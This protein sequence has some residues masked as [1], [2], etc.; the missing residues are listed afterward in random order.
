M[1]VRV[2]VDGRPLLTASQLSVQEG[3]TPINPADESGGTAQVQF[4]VPVFPGWK[5]ADELP[6]LVRDD[7]QGITSGK[8]AA[9]AEQ[10]GSLQVTANSRILNLAVTR[11]AQPYAGTLS[12]AIRYYLSL[13]GI[14]TNISIDAQYDSVPVVFPGWKDDVYQRVARRLCPAFG[15]E[16]SLV[17]DVVVFRPPRGRK[18]ILSRVI[19]VS[20]SIDIS[21]R[22]QRSKLNWYKTRW[23]TDELVYP[24]GGWTPE[25][26]VL[27]VNA[28]EVNVVEGI[29][30]N[31]SLSSIRQPA[32][33]VTVPPTFTGDSVYTVSGTDGLPIPP[34]MWKAYGGDLTVAISEDTRSLTVTIRGMELDQY[35]PYVI[36][37]SSGDGT[38]YSTLRL[39]GSG[40]V[41]DAR[42]MDLG[43]GWSADQAP[44]EY[45]DEVD[46]EFLNTYDR[47]GTGAAWQSAEA[48]G[49][50][51]AISFTAAGINRVD[52]TG[53]AVYATV[54][55]WDAEFEG[56]DTDNWDALW[57][58]RSEQ[59]WEDFWTDKLATGFANQAYGNVAGARIVHDDSWY[60][61]REVTNVG[62]SV[63]G[64]ADLD[65]TVADFDDFFAGM[66][67]DDWDAQWAGVS[68]KQFDVG[69]FPGLR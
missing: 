2:T 10:N 9:L 29:E 19:S 47:A 39:V 53:S 20:E 44:T 30:I 67:T 3:S 11:V 61:I 41:L 68:Q 46:N 15:M 5:T 17:S 36:G 34:A 31:A 8:I 4:T 57:A 32:C 12:G 51:Q 64:S 37:L 33:V 1:G 60:R 49:P 24:P 45:G 28:G 50:T 43:T 55:D 42:V 27:E 63:S 65:N 22:A 38:N 40:T 58:G 16:M 48:T 23:A 54:A 14:T 13:V 56:M 25:V 52:V 7:T 6:I 62:G 26:D 21:A 59:E 35:S 66:T 69:P 18:A